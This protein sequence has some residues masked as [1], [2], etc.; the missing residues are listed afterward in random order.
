MGNRIVISRGDFPLEV[1]HHTA[2][3]EDAYARCKELDSGPENVARHM[4][5]GFG[6]IHY[7]WSVVPEAEQAGAL[8]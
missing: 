2:T 7:S 1:M 4:E 5:W 8:P 6:R 3:I